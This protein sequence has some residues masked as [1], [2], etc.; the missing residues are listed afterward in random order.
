VGNASRDGL[1]EGGGG[2]CRAIVFFRG[3]LG[4]AKKNEL[5]RGGTQRRKNNEGGIKVLCGKGTKKNC[6]R[7]KLVGG[8]PARGLVAEWLGKGVIN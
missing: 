1:G 7:E 3:G 5:V 6:G 8:K 2:D 4:G